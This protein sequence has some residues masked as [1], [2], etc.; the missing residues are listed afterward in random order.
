MLDCQKFN[1]GEELVKKYLEATGRTVI[2]VSKDNQ[3]WLQDTDF[4]AIKGNRT[5]KIEVKYDYN[6]NRYQSMFVEL[7]ANMEKN[8]PGWIDTTKADFIFYVDAISKDCY[9]MSPEHLRAYSAANEYSVR[10]CDRDKYKTSMGAIVPLKQFAE[11]YTVKKIS[12]KNY[13]I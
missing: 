3:Y 7:K 1:P 12:L 11:Q 10:Y 8:V 5:E 4:I 6:M 13:N 2:D 9:I